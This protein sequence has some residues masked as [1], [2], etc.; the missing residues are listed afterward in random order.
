VDN[1]TYQSP[2]YDFVQEN[3]KDA[4]YFLIYLWQKMAGNLYHKKIMNHIND[5]EDLAIKGMCS[6]VCNDHIPF[7]IETESSL[8]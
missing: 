8:R 1:K 6:I 3:T 5:N 2:P 7:R 4:C